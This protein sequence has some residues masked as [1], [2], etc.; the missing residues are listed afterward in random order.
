MLDYLCLSRVS[1]TSPAS[2]APLDGFMGAGFMVTPVSPLAMQVSLAA[3]VGFHYDIIDTPT[4]IDGVSDLD[5]L[6][7]WKPI[8]SNAAVAL[9]VPAAPGG[10]NTRIDIIEV[11]SY[12]RRA[13]TDT[14]DVLN[15]A[16]GVFEPKSVLKTLAWDVQGD[17]GYVVSPANS[18]TAIGYKTGVAGSPG[19]V[20]ATSPGYIK[21][22]EIQVGSSVLTIDADKIVDARQL[23]FPGNCMTAAILMTTPVSGPLTPMLEEAICPP[24]LQPVAVTQSLT[25]AEADLYII[26]SMPTSYIPIAQVSIAN[27]PTIVTAPYLKAVPS[28]VTVDSSLQ[29]LLGGAQASPATKVAV[30]QKVVKIN[31]KCVPAPSTALQYAVTV[32]V[33]GG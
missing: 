26:G 7:R 32:T 18:T 1:M 20:P 29:T 8:Y 14:R 6:S 28:V 12:R 11:K 23:L 16:T 9:N 25:N 5:D 17:I 15:V 10:P 21:V 27:S 3:G 13:D 31:L 30:G 19:V 4:D 33:R 2:G 22:A 24:G